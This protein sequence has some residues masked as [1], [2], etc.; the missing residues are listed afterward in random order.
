MNYVPCVYVLVGGLTAWRLADGWGGLVLAAL[1]WIYV[2]PP[3][4]CRAAMLAWGRPAGRGLTQACRAYKVWWFVNQMQVIHNRFP[5][6]D[7][8]LRLFPGAY[9]AWLRCWGSSVSPLVHW[10]P[11]SRV[12]DRSLLVVERLAVIGMDAGFAGHLGTFDAEGTYRLDVAPSIVREG[13]I[14]GGKSG[15]GPGCELGPGEILPVGKL[16]PPFTTWTG[17]RKIHQPRDMP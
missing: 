14:M 9:A 3:L 1:L 17:G 2:V 7:E 8:F 16:L 13:A 6:F 4:V 10:A 11:G 5:M 15:L 12:V